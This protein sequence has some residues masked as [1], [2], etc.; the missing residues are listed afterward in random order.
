MIGRLSQC[1]HRG[2]Q[3]VSAGASSSRLDALLPRLSRWR[4]RTRW[5]QRKLNAAP[6]AMRIIVIVATILA[7]FCAANLVY[8]VVRKPTEM[9]FP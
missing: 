5:A 3:S 1:S 6:P 9:F 2:G 8:Q 4:Q 7:V